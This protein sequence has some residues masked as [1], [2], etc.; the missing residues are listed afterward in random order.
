[1]TRDDIL[2]HP[3]GKP[4]GSRHLPRRAWARTLAKG[5]KTLLGF[6]AVGCAIAATASPPISAAPPPAFNTPITAHPL[7]KADVDA[8]LDGLM[9]YALARGD[10]A[11]AVVTV[12]KDGQPL[13]ERGFGYADVASRKPVDPART[14]FRPGSISKLMTWTA[15]MQLVERGK[16]D[17]DADVNRYIDFTIPAFRGKP[18]TLRNLMQHTTGFDDSARKLIQFGDARPEPL[19][20]ALREA[21]PRRILPPGTITAY[22]NYGVALAG[23]IVERVSGMPFEDYIERN[24]FAPLGMKR[25][26]FRHP[27]PV[28]L[29]SDMASGYG[30]ASGA[31]M[32]YELVQ[33][34]PAGNMATTGSDIDRFMIAHLSRSGALLKPSTFDLMYNSTN[35]ILPRS[36]RMALGFFAEDRNGHR[37]RSHAGD[38]VFFHSHLWLF[39]DDQVGVFLSLNS[40]GAGDAATAIRIAFFSDFTD[41]YFP[42]DIAAT[43]RK[44]PPAQAARDAR[45]MAGQYWNSWRFDTNFFRI[46]SLFTQ[47]TVTAR[48]GAIQLSQDPG[49]GGAPRAWTE[50]APMLWQARDTGNLLEARIVDGKVERFATLPYSNYTPVPWSLSAVWL[51]P[52]GQIALL[53]VALAAAR[54]PVMAVANRWWGRKADRSGGRRWRS[55]ALGA[56]ALALLLAM[57]GWYHVMTVGVADMSALNGGYDRMFILLQATTSIATFALTGLAAWTMISGWAARG[58]IVRLASVLLLLA[59]AILLYIGLAFHLIGMTLRY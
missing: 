5:W 27:L 46:Y 28:S 32:P 12:V 31:A 23:Y 17:L 25:S 50:I 4:R 48:D 39:I 49:L 9:P 21:L 35:D 40:A 1:M 34:K 45:L 55:H 58:W 29:R 37:V 7:T 44:P 15:V 33:L 26:T 57:G 30:V 3:K 36:D 16:L 2:P 20:Q 11:G 56:A 51:V 38:T 14:L 41:R 53:I 13:T 6:G 22:S 24:I 19:G 54:W 18:V 8:W 47:T 43:Y 59:G 42:G 10:I 52:A